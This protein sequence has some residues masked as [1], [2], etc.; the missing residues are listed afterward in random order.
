MQKQKVPFWA[1]IAQE[2]TGIGAKCNVFTNS[3]PEIDQK[4]PSGRKIQTDVVIDNAY[5]CIDCFKFLIKDTYL[6]T[7]YL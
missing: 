6:V 7:C 3:K 1:Q 5:V 4:V 2:C